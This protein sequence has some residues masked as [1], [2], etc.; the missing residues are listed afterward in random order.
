MLA[1]PAPIKRKTYIGLLEVGLLFVEAVL[2]D[3]G[4]SQQTLLEA[5]Q[6]LVLHLNGRLLFQRDARVVVSA[7]L[8]DGEEHVLRL[9]LL[10]VVLVV[11]L[12]HA[13]LVTGLCID[14]LLKDATEDV[15]LVLSRSLLI[16]G[17]FSFR[18]LTK[19]RCHLLLLRVDLL[20]AVHL[21]LV[22]LFLDLLLLGL[23]L[24]L[25]IDVVDVGVADQVVTIPL[26]VARRDL[27]FLIVVVDVDLLLL[28]VELRLLDLIGGWQVRIELE[29][30]GHLVD[31]HV[32]V[33]VVLLEAQRLLI[34]QI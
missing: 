1:T 30:L 12:A 31:E 3:G 2:N 23:L 18:A 4:A 11:L 24:V 16:N 17:L 22:V 32:L 8:E 25:V 29:L 27:A 7:L 6:R 33:V 19:F 21:Q 14:G 5:A 13:H 15:L 9:L 20:V 34:Q 10:L 26:L 28:D